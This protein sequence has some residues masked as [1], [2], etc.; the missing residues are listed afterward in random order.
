MTRTLALAF[1]ALAL[2][3]AQATANADKT[4][5][6]LTAELTFASIDRS[7]KG[8]VHQGDLERF[9]DEVFV[10]MDSDDNSRLTYS[11]FATWDPGFSAIAAADGKSDAYV[12][13]TKIVFAFWDRDGD[14]VLTVPEM[15]FAMASDFRRAD[16]N[17]DA[18]LSENEFLMGFAVI[19][20]MRA[21]IRPDL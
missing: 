9:R 5:G 18:V 6:R 4:E 2:L 15:R 11:E 16:L 7:G 1:S 8:Y 13:A 12:T 19:V 10:S 3:S 21:A 20:A 17:D 14:G